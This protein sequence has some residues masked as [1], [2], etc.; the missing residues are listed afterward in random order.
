M[1]ISSGG[2]HLRECR[3]LARR[4]VAGMLV[5]VGGLYRYAYLDGLIPRNPA[6]VVRGPRCPRISTTNGLARDELADML[7]AAENDDDP[8]VSALVCLL[9]LNGLRHGETLAIDIEHLGTYG[10]LHTVHL[11]ERKNGASQTVSLSERTARAVLAARGERDSGPLLLGP[12]RVGRMRR[13]IAASRVRRI[14]TQVGITRRI[15]PHSFRHAF[16]TLSRDAGAHDRDIMAS[17]GHRD[18]SMI[19]YYDQARAAIERNA[20]H[21]LTAYL[22]AA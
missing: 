16:V 18:P 11:P 13:Q 10:S 22:N 20:T 8:M 9:A 14:A 2:R 5:A 6:A 19:V 3:G 21:L 12:R 4:T 7:A 17:T 1:P 15:T